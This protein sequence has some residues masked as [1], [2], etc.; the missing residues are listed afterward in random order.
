[1]ISN[2]EKIEAQ[3]EILNVVVKD[4]IK[5]IKH[6][7]KEIIAQK[8]D[9]RDFGYYEDC[10][11]FYREQ[12]IETEAVIE[13]LIKQKIHFERKRKHLKNQLSN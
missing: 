12:V 6:L 3:R 10:G 13:E 1:M 2:S 7:Q 4:I 9:R 11:S 8:E 5:R